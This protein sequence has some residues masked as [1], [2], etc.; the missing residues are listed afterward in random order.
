MGAFAATV[1]ANA[2]AASSPMV[3]ATDTQSVM[4]ALG[5]AGYEASFNARSEDGGEAFIQ[6]ETAD[7]ISTV[8]F[9]DCEEAV[10]DFCE[11]LIL[12]TW[13]DRETPISDELVAAANRN[14]KYVSV[15]RDDDG[16][17]VME[18]AVLTRNEGIP[19]TVFI[20]AFERYVS[21]ASD[22]GDFAFEGDPE[23]DD[24]PDDASDGETK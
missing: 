5:T 2:Q 8:R 22:F 12:S 13:W 6:V 10:P 15:Y 18:W 19:A 7:G 14:H 21:V 20:D 3:S 9:S 23:P 17:P 4:N 16:D 11:T 24:V 1:A